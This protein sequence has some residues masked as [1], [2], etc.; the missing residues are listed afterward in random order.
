M[1]N[2]KLDKWQKD[3]L[4]TEGDKI[5]CTGR[6][7]GKSVICSIDA[8]EYAVNNSNKIILIIAP[9]ERQA[10]YLFEKILGYLAAQHPQKLRKRG[11]FRPTKTRIHL[12]NGTIIRCLP[13]GTAGIGIRGYTVH[14]LYVDEASRVPEDV[15]GA[16][17]PMLLTTGGS[18]ILLSTPF[19][20]QGEFH[21][22]W[23]NKDSAYDSFSRFSIDSEE[24]IRNRPICSSW[25]EKQREMGLQKI[26]QAKSRMSKREYAQEYLG[27]F[28]QDLHRWF[29]D[30]LINSICTL[31]RP[32][33]ISRKYTH[34]LGCDIARMGEDEGTYEIIMKI[35]KDNLVQVENIVTRKKLTTETEARILELDRRYNFERIFIDAG[36]GTLGVSI[37]DHLLNIDQ[38]KRKIEAINNRARPLDRDGKSKT[39]L[40]KED[41]YSNLLALME[42]R[43]IK[44]L[45]DEDLIE[46]LRSIQYEYL[47]SEGK[48]TRL[49]I[50]GEYSH[51]VE[52][53]IRA[54]WCVKYKDL[55]IWVRS[56]KV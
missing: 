30:E 9:T 33:I 35:N 12:N 13:T 42:Q 29:S 47:M 34:F 56:I 44:L 40:L 3:F 28:V 54:A 5:L 41:L 19:G 25:T 11:K 10:F 6:Q 38:T 18:T 46:S 24:V 45:D 23:I 55:S 39:R 32:L 43:K 26:E 37:F 17:T 21:R 31:K 53:L 1:L 7:V 4:D 2:L 15:W 49:R 50:F 51:I 52:G 20:A 14:R 16:V 8:G 22:V 48:P 27:E 36:S